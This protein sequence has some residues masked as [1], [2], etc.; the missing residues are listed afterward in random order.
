M[1]ALVPDRVICCPGVWCQRVIK[2]VPHMLIEGSGAGEDGVGSASGAARRNTCMLKR[3]KASAITF[4]LPG[5]CCTVAEKLNLA[6]QRNSCLR[7]CIILGH[8]DVP[9]HTVATALLSQTKEIR[10]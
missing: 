6:A 1:K 9:E 5:V 3:E 10:F 2:K 4:S 8:L 7:S